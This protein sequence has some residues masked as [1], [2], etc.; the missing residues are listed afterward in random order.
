MMNGCFPGSLD[1]SGPRKGR[2]VDATTGGPIQGAVVRAVWIRHDNP[3]PDGWGHH[4]IFVRAVTDKKGFF[5]LES[6]RRRRGFFGTDHSVSVAAKGYIDAVFIVDPS[7]RPLPKDTREFPFI[8]TSVRRRLPAEMTI[9]LKPAIPVLLT[10]FRS[11]NALYRSIAKRELRK[12][13]KV[14]FGCDP[15]K[16]E[17]AVA[18][19][20]KVPSRLPESRAAAGFVI[21]P[22]NGNDD[23]EIKFPKCGRGKSDLIDAAFS[24][25]VNRVRRLLAAGADVHE[26][27][28]SCDTALLAAARGARPEIVK[29]LLA[30]GAKVNARNDRCETALMLAAFSGSKETVNLLLAAG[31]DVNAR[32]KDC[33]TASLKAHIMRNKEIIAILTASA[34]A[35]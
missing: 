9:R 16:W 14:D 10:V 27:N 23:P 11:E 7:E 31:A 13:L 19:N 26:R 22:G 35:K 30:A 15:R 5:R 12:L 3:Y 29:L 25:D 18:G 33:E 6:P 20:E 1:F 34:P 21:C 32:D 28:R 2:V 4:T 8:E 24:G 17:S